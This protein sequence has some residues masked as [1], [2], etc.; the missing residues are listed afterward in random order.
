[1]TALSGESS[2]VCSPREYRDNTRNVFRKLAIAPLLL[3]CVFISL[4]FGRPASRDFISYW[5]AAKLLVR[6]NDP[7]SAERVFELEKA[8]GDLAS[9]PIIM[10]NPPGAMFL[11]APLALGNPFVTLFFW[12]VASIGCIFAFARLLGV[13]SKDRAFAFVFA[14]TVS[15][16]FLGQ[17]SAFL[18]L[19]FAL[20]L[21]LQQRHPFLAGAA[22]LLMAIKPHLFLIFWAVLF[23]ECIYR[24]RFLILAGGA[25]ALTAA[26]AFAMLLDPRIWQQY[27]AM[28][29]ASSLDHESFP[30]VSMFF[31]LLTNR[32]SFWL[33]FVPS[34][35]GIIWGLWY[36]R[37]N[38]HLW[39][40]SVHG[41]LLM[42]VTVTLSPYGWFADSIVLLPCITAALASPAKRKYSTQILIAINTI[43]LVI[44]LVVRARITSLAYAWLPLAISIWFL[45]AFKRPQYSSTLLANQV[46][47]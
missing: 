39:D 18:L 16:I 26:T 13:S 46:A 20:F 38:R 22:L 28:L 24:R 35:L 34:S 8:Q 4:F 10:R 12:T 45:Y 29:R 23:V 47:E 40:W 9:D 32:G 43:A 14:P 1:M 31:R 30:T 5:S 44:L 19:G 33:L 2:E 42:L 25:T 21:H 6:H 7:Y 17:S 36:Y 15:C 41:M 27:W 11:V 37:H 3:A